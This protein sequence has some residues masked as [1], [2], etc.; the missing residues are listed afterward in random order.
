MKHHRSRYDGPDCPEDATHGPLL[1]APDGRG[2][3]CPH[4]AHDGRP[5]GH[6]EGPSA[7][8]RSRFTTAEV[9]R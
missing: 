3:Y 4:V 6:A 8:T 7:P 1:A 9:S 5:R 2:W